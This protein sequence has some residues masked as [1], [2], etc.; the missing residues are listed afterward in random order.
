[1]FDQAAPGIM[2]TG[3]I[4]VGGAMVLFF[5]PDAQRRR[6][7]KCDLTYIPILEFILGVVVCGFGLW[8]NST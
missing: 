5:G 1:M 2:I 8:I 7:G 3:C 6:Q 4:I